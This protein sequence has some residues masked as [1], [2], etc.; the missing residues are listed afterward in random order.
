MPIQGT[1]G[2]IRV[3]HLNVVKTSIYLK[4]LDGEI[5]RGTDREK[6][7][8]YVPYGGK[9]DIALFDRT[10]ASLKQGDIAGFMRLGYVNAFVVRS[11]RSGTYEELTYAGN[12]VT[13]TNTWTDS[14]KTSRIERSVFTYSGN[15]ITTEVKTQYDNK[16]NIV[17]QV[18]FTFTYA[19]GKIVSVTETVL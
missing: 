10:L 13:E 19:G 14:T 3:V 11:L 9:I 12:K 6:V 5:N 8:C 1:T 7:P 4:D 2:Y 17:D 15:D 18:Q 16:N